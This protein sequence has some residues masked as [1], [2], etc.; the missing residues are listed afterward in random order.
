MYTNQ[1]GPAPQPRFFVGCSPSRAA[2]I[3]SRD[4]DCAGVMV[5][6]NQLWTR[7]GDFPI[8]DWILDSGAFTE[9]ARHG[10]YRYDVA[11]YWRQI[12]RWRRCGN[13]L[14]AVAQDWMCEPFVLAKTGCTVDE[15]QRRTVA[16]YNE[17]MSLA[18]GTVYIMPVL[19]GYTVLEYLDCLALYGERLRPGA[20]VGVGSVCRRNSD[21]GQVADILGAIKAVR[22]DLRLHGFGLKKTALT[23]PRICQLLYSCDSFA[24]SVMR[25]WADVAMTEIEAITHYVEN[26]YTQAKPSPTAGAG[27]GQGRKAKWKHTPT[28]AIRV[29]AKFAARL[30]ALAREWDSAGE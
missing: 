9:V 27:N 2:D 22:P 17:L 18:D 21:P 25:Q 5:S 3:A 15:H 1:P 26:L 30:V 8:G 4:L 20:W 11:H 19:Q 29:P 6:V 14:A 28:T 7:K 13:L 16:R 23:S 24:W 12:Q 10:G